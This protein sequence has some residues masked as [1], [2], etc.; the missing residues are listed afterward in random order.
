MTNDTIRFN[1]MSTLA[2]LT[3]LGR[4]RLSQNFFMRDMLYSEVSNWYGVPNHPEDPE[5]AIAA[6]EK[7]AQLVLEPLTAAFGRISVRSAYR[8]PLLNDYCHRLYTQG[9]T[10]AWCTC[11]ED[12]AAYHIWDRRD[13]KGLMG[14]AATI[15]IP[16]YIDHFEKTRDWRPLGWWMRDHLEHYASVQFFRTLC[17][18][19]IQW[20]EG[21]SSQ[22]IGYLDPPTRLTLTERGAADFEGDHSAQYAGVVCASAPLRASS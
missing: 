14:A 13:A 7:L 20:Y 19:N 17:A 21:P 16:S 22:S 6:G 3:A 11:N 2:D 15:V 1:K 10:D 4:R 8:S 18:F 12:N 5:L 9:V